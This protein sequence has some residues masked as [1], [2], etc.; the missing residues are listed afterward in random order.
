MN[1]NYDMPLHVTSSVITEVAPLLLLLRS[2]IDFKA[3]VIEE[4][5]AHLHPALQRKMA[6]FIIRLQHVNNMLRLNGLQDRKSRMEVFQYADS[7][8][9]DA[10]EVG[11]YQFS[12]GQRGEESIVEELLPG[13]N[14]FVVPTFN[15][16]L[17][18]F[19]EEIY[20]IQ[21]DGD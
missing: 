14:G 13:S 6:R 19:L 5:E 10:G 8:L 3:I 15:D 16:A 11:V 4:P 12:N 21:G 7:D 9:L 18:D 20:A 17:S 2:N 1:E